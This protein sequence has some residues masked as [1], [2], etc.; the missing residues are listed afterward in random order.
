MAAGEVNTLLCFLLSIER[1]STLEQPFHIAWFV[2][3]I[4]TLDQWLLYQDFLKY[5]LVIYHSYP[6]VTFP[7]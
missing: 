4:A 2:P 5:I 1:A 3:F 6:N 7:I